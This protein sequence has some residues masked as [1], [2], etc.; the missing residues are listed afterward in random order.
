MVYEPQLAFLRNLLKDMNISSCVL[1]NPQQH[2]PP[3]IDLFLRA[4]LFGISNYAD[5]L[6]NSMAQ[7]HDKT[8]YRFFDEYDCYY[9]FLRLP[10]PDA[11]FFVGPYLLSLPSQKRMDQRAASLKL[12]QEQTGKMQLYYTALPLLDDE[13]WLITMVN[14]FAVHLWG[15]KEQYSMEYV[16]YPIPDRYAPIAYSPSPA[17]GEAHVFDLFALEEHYESENKLME[18]VSKGK[19]QLVTATASTVFNN[20]AER[21]LNDSLRDRKNYLIILKT[22]LRKAAGQGGVHP[23]HLHRL[24]SHYAGL[25]ENVRTIKQSISLQENM[26]RDFC[27]LVKRHSLSKYSYYVGHAITL[28]QYDLTADLRLKTIA[29]MLNVNSSYLSGLFHREVGSTLTEYI[30]QQ[31]IS[32]GIHLLQTTSKP[33]QEIAAEC[34]IHDVNYFIKLFKKHTG[35]TP[36][37][38][39]EQS[40]K[41]A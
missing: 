11:Y 3:E 33:V 4:E 9:I 39:R 32:R 12:T 10:R 28:V 7:A 31:R 38:Y 37:R 30:N 26:I 13:N 6:Q 41:E 18:A 20:G 34:G 35:F 16:D 40:G 17:Q 29:Q 21:R 8:V 22:L 25:I 5:F 19:L 36:S 27:Q 2:I 24:S 14:T 1:E 15:D 23:I